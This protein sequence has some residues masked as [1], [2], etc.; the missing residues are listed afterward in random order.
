MR[1]G[2]IVRATKRKGIFILLLLLPWIKSRKKFSNLGYFLS[3]MIY[4]MNFY[5]IIQLKLEHLWQR[6][7]HYSGSLIMTRLKNS[8]LTGWDFKLWINIH[9]VIIS[10]YSCKSNF[11]EIEIHLTEHHG[12]CALAQNIYRRFCW[13]AKIPYRITSKKS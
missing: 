4:S 5:S 13:I 11:E 2:F 9:L 6:L 10:P 3:Y 1:W 7:N 8:M 12:D